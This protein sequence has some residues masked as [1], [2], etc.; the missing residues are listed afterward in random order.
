AP[1]QLNP[2]PVS[3]SQ[4]N[5]VWTDNSTNETGF[6]IA[7]STN[8][9][10]PYADIFTVAANTA[11]Y[12]STGLVENTTYYYVVR[13]VNTQGDSTNSAE[14]EATT[15]AINPHIPVITGQPQSVAIRLGQSAVFSV[16]A[17]GTPKLHY[18][19]RLNGIPLSGATNS[20]LTIDSAG[21]TNAG[22]Y[23]VLVTNAY[24]SALSSNALLGLTTVAGTGDDSFE[25]ITL[26]PSATNVIAIAAGAWHSLA[27]QADGTVA[28]WG[29]DADG[30]SDAP[31]A[32]TNA[33]A[34]A[35]GGYHSLAIS[36]SGAVT[37]WGADDYGQTNLPAGLR[38]VIG[39]SAGTW[40]NL[41]LRADGSVVAWGDNSWGQTNVPIGLSN[42]VAVSAG[43]NHSLALK[44]DGTVMAWGE[45][46]NSDGTFVGQSVVPPGLTNVV[47]IAAG[48]Y[49]SLAVKGDGSVVAWGDNTQNQVGGA[50][51]ISNVVAVAGGGS[52]SVAL[53]SDGTVLAWGADWNGQCDIA[54]A[55]FPA[56]GIA[57][58]RNHTLLLL[59][60]AL[61][62]P[63][64]L[65]PAWKARRFTALAQTLNRKNYVLEFKDSLAAT[66]WTS[67]PPVSGNG[68]LRL[69]PDT[70]ATVAQRFYRTWQW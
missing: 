63:R 10:G 17:T 20:N 25:Q 8:S 15:L 6:T 35:A 33:L 65:S 34:I 47:A 30:Q 27:L 7:S 53:R 14:A 21:T 69:L 70:N 67:L 43:G 12:S 24:G 22:A 37:A 18:Q 40:H 61:P 41:A 28:A 31:A 58:G 66:N 39:I 36:S 26:P 5:L 52:H 50:G 2:T 59:E 49:H 29:D 11:T 13:A 9:G 16:A 19:W 46:N 38:N 23:V 54:P 48:E 44:A 4:I 45:N 32:L 55:L 57:A 60:G 51:G 68:A 62:V 56:V 1:S 3:P 64:L 42:V